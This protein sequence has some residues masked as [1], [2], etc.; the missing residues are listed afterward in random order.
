M[1]APPQEEKF[2]NKCVETVLGKMTKAHDLIGRVEQC[3]Q[4]VK[5][6]DGKESSECRASQRLAAEWGNSRRRVS[7]GAF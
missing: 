7:L 3:V 4:P 2:L 1:N 6:K 5:D